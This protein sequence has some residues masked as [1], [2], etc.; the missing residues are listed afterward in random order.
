MADLVPWLRNPVN[1]KTTLKFD[2]ASQL[3][4]KRAIFSIFQREVA[5]SNKLLTL[6]CYLKQFTKICRKWA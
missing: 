4:N 6:N 3:L 2:C 5:Q 1:S